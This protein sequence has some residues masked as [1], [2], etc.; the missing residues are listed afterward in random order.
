MWDEWLSQA[1]KFSRHP[2]PMLG[3]GLVR[4][5]VRRFVKPEAYRPG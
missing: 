1:A 2:S 4:G 3:W 5:M